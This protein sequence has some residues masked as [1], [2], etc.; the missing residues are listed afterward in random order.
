[1]RLTSKSFSYGVFQTEMLNLQELI[2]NC[3]PTFINITHFLKLDERRS[4][5]HFSHQKLITLNNCLGVYNLSCHQDQ[6]F[7]IPYY[8]PIPLTIKIM[9]FK[10]PGQRTILFTS[11][12]LS[13]NMQE[14]L[15]TYS[16]VRGC[17]FV[18]LFLP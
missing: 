8:L 12:L 10:R 13:T 17:M 15:D 11:V 3:F 6:I 16:G 18:P 2:K 4:S 9:L 5:A 14:A 1:M 7:D